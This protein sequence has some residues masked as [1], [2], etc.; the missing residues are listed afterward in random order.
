MSYK[1]IVIIDYNMGNLRSVYNATR[2]LGLDVELTSSKRNISDSYGIILPGVGAFGDAIKNIKELG[3]FDLI[4]EQI[5]KG[6]PYLGICLGLQLLFETSE[7]SNNYRGF[8]IF[9]GNS[10]M[11]QSKEIKIPHIGWNSINIKKKASNLLKDIKTG[12]YF[13]F[14]HSYYVKPKDSGII[15]A[16]TEYGEEFVSAVNRDN[17]FGVQFHPEKSHDMGLKVLKNFANICC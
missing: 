1:K 16:T 7:E 10:I 4:I 11:F 12:E 2:F 13:Y 3:L 14:V 17:I 8:S 6:K 15:L 9:E 5:N